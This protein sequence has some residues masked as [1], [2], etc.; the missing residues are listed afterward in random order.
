M[1]LYTY[2]ST[3]KQLNGDQSRAHVTDHPYFKHLLAKNVEFYR[4]GPTHL[5]QSSVLRSTRLDTMRRLLA[6]ARLE[7][8][9][10]AEVDEEELD[11]DEIFEEE[12]A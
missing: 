1:W 10:D 5:S 6:L 4:S 11:A 9:P 12:Y 7:N 2:E 3:L 8:D